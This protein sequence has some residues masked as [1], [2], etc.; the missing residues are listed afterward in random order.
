MKI[1][2]IIIVLVVSLW[3]TEITNIEPL[4]LES[5]WD[6]PVLVANNA[7]YMMYRDGRVVKYEGQIKRSSKEVR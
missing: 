5:R 6:L 1:G 7:I 4:V 3:P 2:M